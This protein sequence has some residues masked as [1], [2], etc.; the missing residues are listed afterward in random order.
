MV[1]LVDL[2]PDPDVVVALEPEELGLRLLPV[3]ASWPRFQELQLEILL[4]YLIGNSTAPA[5]SGQYPQNRRVEIA[6]AATE[7]WAWLENATLLIKHPPYAPSQAASRLLSRRAQQ[8]A[9]EPDPRQVFS[10]RLL[11]KDSLHPSIREDVWALYHRGKFDTAIFEAMKAVE[12]AVRDAA[13]LTT[14]DYGTNLMRKAFHS[15]T[16]A[17]TDPTAE[18]AE[19]EARSN[20]FAGTIG[21]YKN[22]QSHQKVGLDDAA[23]AAEIVM[24]ASHLLRI[25]D[26][27]RPAP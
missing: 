19:R 17:L 21:A 3:L 23:E 16:G 15:T 12:V 20:L 5:P 4:H 9:K 2:I 6:I 14:A 1:Q 22:A 18:A 7:A 25:V 8:L 11:P 13:G 24:L 26:S 10:A 27:R